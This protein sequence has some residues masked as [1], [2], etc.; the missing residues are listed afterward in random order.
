MMPNVR[1]SA[2]LMPGCF[3]DNFARYVLFLRS[4]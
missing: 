1:L 4:V 3:Q 2:Y